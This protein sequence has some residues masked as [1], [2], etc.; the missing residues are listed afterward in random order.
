MEIAK[1]LLSDAGLRAI[2]ILF[3]NDNISNLNADYSIYW[4]VDLSYVC[5]GNTAR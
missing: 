4:N 5:A 2:N 1:H 3:I